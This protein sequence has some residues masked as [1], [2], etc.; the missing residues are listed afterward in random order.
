MLPMN[1]VLAAHGTNLVIKNYNRD[2]K[3][4]QFV[5]NQKKKAILSNHPSYKRYS[6]SIQSRGRSSNLALEVSYTRWW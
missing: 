4:Q 1:R 5:F 2:D 3:A 6:L